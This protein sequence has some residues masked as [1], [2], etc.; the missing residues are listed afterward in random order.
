MLN[1]RFLRIKVFQTLYAFAQEEQ[2]N[3]AAFRSR[4]LAGVDKTWELYLFCLSFPLEFHHFVT[5]ELELQKGK[6][7]PQ[8]AIIKPLQAYANNTILLQMDNSPALKEAFKKINP[9]WKDT[10]DFNRKIY[11]EIRVLPFFEEYGSKPNH[12]YSEDRNFLL[13]IFEQLFAES[14]H[15]NSYVEEIFL[16]WED[17]QVVILS[18]LQKMMGAL[19]ETKADFLLSPHKDKEEDLRF[20]KDLFDLCLA[21]KQE[22]DELIIA[23]TQN[24]DQDRIAVVDLHLMRLALVEILFMPLVPVKVSINEY[25]EIAKLY[26]T[27]SSHG[28]INGILDKIQLQLRKEN[29]IQK[30]GRGL[31]E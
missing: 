11:N 16:N 17:D 22:L 21:H 25:L 6:Y 5:Q 13:A 4:L 14:E 18:G 31:Q 9:L 12:T 3:A 29:R 2:A 8:E 23:K 30:Q 1:R 28:F 15:F 27:P 7:F 26:S 10:A 24:W 20:M 19:K